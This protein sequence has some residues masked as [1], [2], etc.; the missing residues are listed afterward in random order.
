[1]VIPSFI[2]VAGTTGSGKTTVAQSLATA[3][4]YHFCDA[5]DYHPAENKEKM[6]N[7]IGLTDEDRL[8]WLTRLR[9][10]SLQYS[11]L[12][13]ACSALKRSYRE[14]LA[15]GRP[16]SQC[17]FVFLEVPDDIL[18]ERVKRRQNHYAKADLIQSQLLTLERPT[19]EEKNAISVNGNQSPE[20]VLADVLLALK[21]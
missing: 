5:D 18:M 3:L 4:G 12:V 13:L 20:K 1:M 2:V 17:T 8:P 15:A 14:L 7:G 6:A 9:E 19:E 21:K 10:L 11:H 16:P